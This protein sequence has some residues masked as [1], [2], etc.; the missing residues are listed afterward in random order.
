MDILMFAQKY[1]I[2]VTVTNGLKY[3]MWI[4]SGIYTGK[5]I[6]WETDSESIEMTVLTR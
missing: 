1:A 3:P 5:K 2:N 4:S 6:I